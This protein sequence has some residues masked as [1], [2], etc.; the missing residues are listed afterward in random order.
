MRIFQQIYTYNH[1]MK[2]LELVVLKLF[3][4]VYWKQ[5]LFQEYKM[6]KKFPNEEEREA[7]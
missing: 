4:S 2:V 6:L 7:L 5:I 1:L 3:L